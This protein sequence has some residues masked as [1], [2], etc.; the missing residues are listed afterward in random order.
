MDVTGGGTDTFAAPTAKY[1]SGAV[2]PP[3]HGGTHGDQGSGSGTRKDS[4]AP[5]KKA[6]AGSS[7]AKE[8]VSV[9]ERGIDEWDAKTAEMVKLS[10]R[11]GANYELIGGE[12]KGWRAMYMEMNVDINICKKAVEKFCAHI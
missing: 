6:T 11:L 2:A 1:A 10:T 12:F 8:K 3:K 4:S 5:M 9:S 7:F